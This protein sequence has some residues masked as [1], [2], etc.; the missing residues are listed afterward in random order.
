MPKFVLMGALAQEQIY[1]EAMFQSLA[2]HTPDLA[3]AHAD[4]L[5]AE[6]SGTAVVDEWEPPSTDRIIK[7]MKAA[8]QWENN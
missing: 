5:R 6:Y 8:G 2:V 4:Q 1:N 7:N 3:K